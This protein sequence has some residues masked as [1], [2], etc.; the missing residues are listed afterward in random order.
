MT[1][2]IVDLRQRIDNSKLGHLD[3]VYINRA[4]AL[5]RS[6]AESI[7]PLLPDDY[8]VAIDGSTNSSA[9]NI[10]KFDAH[11]DGG[12]KVVATL[13]H[14]NVSGGLEVDIHDLSDPTG[15]LIY[16]KLSKRGLKCVSRTDKTASYTLSVIRH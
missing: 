1:K 5:V 15:K 6:V 12:R 10:S 11:S 7:I 14:C 4:E 8:S 2:N 9:Y 13:R 3:R 16:N